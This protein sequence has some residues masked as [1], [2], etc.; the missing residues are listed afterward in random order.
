[1][2]EHGEL[3]HQPANE[4]VVRPAVVDILRQVYDAAT[5]ADALAVLDYTRAGLLAE[6]DRC[7]HDDSYQ[8]RLDELGRLNDLRD[9]IEYSGGTRNAFLFYSKE[10]EIVPG[11]GNGAY[12]PWR[13]ATDRPEPLIWRKP[14]ATAAATAI[15]PAP[16]G[17]VKAIAIAWESRRFKLSSEKGRREVKTV[18]RDMG[19]IML[20][21]TAAREAT[22]NRL[23]GRVADKRRVIEQV[24]HG[25]PVDRAV[26]G[27]RRTEREFNRTRRNI[28]AVRRLYQTS[29]S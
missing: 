29:M 18:V 21:Q 17:R 16:E 5:P 28:T 1:M 3:L 27:A 22:T 20:G 13:N 4:P 23:N 19:K 15:A 7:A 11:D 24:C 9:Y 12:I 10:Q 2:I 25:R 26:R 6:A 8:S 14:A